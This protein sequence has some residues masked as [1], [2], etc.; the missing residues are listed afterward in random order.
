MENKTGTPYTDAPYTMWLGH[1]TT[2]A[3]SAGLATVDVLKHK[4]TD[5]KGAYHTHVTQEQ[6]HDYMRGNAAAGLIIG[7]GFLGLRALFP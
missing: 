3:V 4:G 5:W 1:K 6:R 2:Q 7:V